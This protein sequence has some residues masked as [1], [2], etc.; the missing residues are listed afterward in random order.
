MLLFPKI[1]KWPTK[2]Q[3]MHFLNILSK[4]EKIVFFAFVFL[5][6]TSSIFL[7]SNFYIKNTKVVP[8]SGGMHIEGVIGQP[9]FINP[10][11]A[12]SDADRDLTQLIFSGLMKYNENMEIVPDLIQNYEIENEG[13]TYKFYLKEKLFW[14][15]KAAITADDIIFT[16]KT[17]QNP[18]YKSPLRAN[19]VGVDVE[20]INDL[21]IKFTL[22]KSYASF[23]ENCTLKILPK[24]IWEKVTPENFALDAANIRPIG[25]GIYMIKD[26]K[27]EKDGKIRYITLEKNPMYY[28]Q[29]P[30]ISEI[31]FMFFDDENEIISAA[32]YN[33]IKGFSTGYYLNSS[34][35]WQ[36]YY[37]SLPRYFAIFFNQTNS[38]PLTDKNIRMAL[39]YATNKKEIAKKAF[40]L[41]DNSP[42]LDKII[43]DSPILPNIF[44][45]KQP[46]KTY[47]FDLEKANKLL[48]DAGYKD[49]NNDGTREKT[50]EKKATF[51]FKSNL[52]KGSQSAEVKELQ[53]CLARMPDVYPS[54]EANGYF[55]DKT[56]D[57]VVKFQEKYAKD[58]LEPAGVSKATGS[59]NKLTR[60]KLNE[61]CFGPDVETNE[62]K[63][64]LI[65]VDQGQL[66]KAAEE[67][68]SQLSK[69]GIMVEIQKF[70][71]SQ[72]EQD[73]IKPR[74]YQMLLFG[75]V[76][77]AIPDLLPFWHSSQKI[78][79]GLNLSEYEN[80]EADKLLEDA[81]KNPDSEQRKTNLEQFQNILISD[82]P[83]IFLYCPDYIYWTA[84][85]LE[86]INTSK[87][88]D[89]SKRFT[90]IEN[91][92]MRTKRI[93]K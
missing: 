30:Y 42:V 27:Q 55:G 17:I 29:K 52:E 22:K 31:Q 77:G 39:N 5:L 7:I 46:E 41:A 35:K 37:L 90:G 8:S 19:W 32:Q 40:G 89:P 62:L 21:T 78:D 70:P 9:R 71:I 58:I 18:D 44:G 64:T 69:A 38:K 75:E 93:W 81:R 59:V 43:V 57:A 11:Y 2:P 14:Q 54:G 88:V 34:L 65:T 25:S 79:P 12:N 76:L 24:H 85:N 4:K 92:Y 45:F 1:E 50:I 80:K 51:Q 67:L 15:D 66:V 16:I 60:N 26:M 6:I 61:V 3:W 73:Y 83:G 47:S 72:I 68:K 82:A 36:S 33:K 49:T 13:L 23:I 63:F 28:G 74:N 86:G 84:R 87:I 20:K 53:K 56:Y 10:I 91:W 48:D